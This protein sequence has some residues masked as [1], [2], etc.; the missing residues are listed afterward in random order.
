MSR[1]YIFI[2]EGYFPFPIDMLRYDECHPT[3]SEGVQAIVESFNTDVL[4]H[5]TYIVELR[6]PCYPTEDRWASFLWRVVLV[7]DYAIKRL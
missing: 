7:D 1:T 5:K 4:P 3:T 6:G 2:V